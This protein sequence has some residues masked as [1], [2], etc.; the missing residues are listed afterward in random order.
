MHLRVN[1]SL[2]RIGQLGPTFLILDDAADHPPGEAE[3]IMSVDGR[4][5]QWRVELPE[6]LSSARPRSAIVNCRTVE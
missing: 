5:R 6:G 2:L 1:G 3:I 4:T